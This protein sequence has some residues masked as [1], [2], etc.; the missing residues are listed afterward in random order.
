MVEIK[1]EKNKIEQTIS[2]FED[3]VKK[4]LNREFNRREFSEEKCR[5]C[6]FKDYC[7]GE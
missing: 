6:E 7:R 4:I 2:N 5:E 1:L 3:T